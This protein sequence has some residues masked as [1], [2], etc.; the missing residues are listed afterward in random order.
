MELLL[1]FA[2]FGVI[3]A[4]LLVV[5]SFAS[6]EI[7]YLLQ[8][9]HSQNKIF[10]ICVFA[11]VL[12]AV[13]YGGSKPNDSQSQTNSVSSSLQAIGSASSDFNYLSST[14]QNT[15]TLPLWYMQH[16][17]STND[18][19]GDG[20]PDSWERWT[21][22]NPALNDALV[23]Y[24]GDGVNSI[25]EFQY[26]CDPIR[27]DTDG[28]GLDDN[29]EIDGMLADI[30]DF[31]PLVP[32]NFLIEEEYTPG[33]SIC[34][35]W[36]N[37][38]YENGFNL[39][40]D[41]NNNGYDD[42]YEERMP[43][44]GDYNF[45]VF[46]TIATT[47]TALLSWENNG[48]LIPPCTNKVVKLRLDGSVDTGSIDL[49]AHPEGA[50]LSGLW[51][52]Q[53]LVEYD[54]RYSQESEQNRIK[55]RNGYYIDFDTMESEFIGYINSTQMSR[56][57]YPTGS[58]L[59]LIYR[60]M[61]IE[62]SHWESACRIHG[63]TPYFVLDLKNVDFPLILEFESYRQIVT[64]EIVYLSEELI[65]DFD[66]WDSFLI[67]KEGEED[68]S[69]SY[70]W[71]GFDYYECHQSETTILGAG[72]NT[73]PNNLIVDA[74]SHE[75]L[76][77]QTYTS[78]GPN[79]PIATN[80][81]VKI[82]FSHSWY[83]VNTRNLSLVI[84]DDS[85]DNYTDHCIALKYERFLEIN[86]LD[87]IDEEFVDFKNDIYFKVNGTRSSSNTIRFKDEP[88]SLSAKTFYI[89]LCYEGCENIFD[90]LWITVYSEEDLTEFNSWYNSN[91]SDLGWIAAL[92]KPYRTIK[93]ANGELFDPEP[94]NPGYWSE[95]SSINSYLH[96]NASYEMR[97]E[98]TLTQGNQA[99]YDSNGVIIT[100]TIAAGTADRYAPYNS[101]GIP[102]S[103]RS[104]RNEDVYP[105]LRAIQID[106]NPCAPDIYFTP[107]NLDRP[108]LYQGEYLNKYLECRS[109]FQSKE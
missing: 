85:K 39:F 11:F 7:R 95:P 18:T 66:N 47:R 90:R 63:P 54:L 79:C 6:K 71:G 60:K 69:L 99:C 76:F 29:I 62:I 68:L 22:T 72:R 44:E 38:A 53:M 21:H 104:H 58:Y 108:C 14:T 28:D 89:E 2:K 37:Y 49:I 67:F 48:I 70:V 94:D 65:R 51:K 78:F 10:Q 98:T 1:F 103:A 34:D 45:D 93:N 106:G 36:N 83:K 16:G 15:P 75:P 61:S 41:E 105:F 46:L 9:V 87:L 43:Y 26:Q 4:G 42:E 102:M 20:I 35:I 33:L 8:R 19:D 107:T 88:K 81:F 82:G 52:A 50:S 109:I 73:I 96:H 30:A 13:L 55:L 40:S 27:K 56:H 59:S 5:F 12:S 31:N 97:T 80:K 74:S 77:H 101:W 25:T 84:T 3:L 64:N 23:D 32:A 17:Y 91:A 92:P 24:D 86:L 100:N 57:S